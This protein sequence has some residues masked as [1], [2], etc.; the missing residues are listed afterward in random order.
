MNIFE[1]GES[2]GVFTVAGKKGERCQ[3]FLVMLPD[4][5]I[6]QYG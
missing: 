1:E 3:V 6:F 5:L 2:L 4:T